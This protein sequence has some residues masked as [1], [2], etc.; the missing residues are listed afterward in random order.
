MLQAMQAPRQTPNLRAIVNNDLATKINA[1]LD[2]GKRFLLDDP[3]WAAEFAPNG[4]VAVISS[5]KQQRMN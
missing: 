1:T 3:T 2:A 5:K 4:T